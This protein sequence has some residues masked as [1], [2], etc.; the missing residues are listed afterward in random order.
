MAYAAAAGELR[1][2]GVFAALESANGAFLMFQ[3]V[4]HNNQSWA[5]KA[6]R[7]TE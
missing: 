6:E 4:W 3:A 2:L 5:N 1:D 7:I